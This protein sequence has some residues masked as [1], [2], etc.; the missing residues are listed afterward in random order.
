ML[1]AGVR[2]NLIY[3]NNRP[4]HIQ[5]KDVVKIVP[6]KLI[7]DGIEVETQAGTTIMETADQMGIEIPRLCYDPELSIYGGCR[8]CVVEVEGM[9]N[10][11]ASCCT[12]AQPGMVIH[13]KNDRVIEARR[14]ILSLMLADHPQNCMTCDKMGDC[15]LAR[16]CY[17]YGV[18]KSRFERSKPVYLIDDSNPFIIRDPNKCILCGKC[19]RACTEVSGIGNLSFAFRSNRTKVATAGDL[20][21]I[22]SDC[23]FC[24]AC[25]A[26]CPTGALVERSMHGKGRRWETEKIKTTCSFCGT[27][28]NFDLVVKDEKVIGVQSNPSSEVNGRS[29]CVKGRFGWDYIYNEKRLTTPLIKKNGQFEPASWE[30]ALALTATRL[31]ETKAQHGPDALAVL[32]SARCTNEDNYLLQK[33]TRAALGTNN[34]DHC[35][36]T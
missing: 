28:C 5:A 9:R 15:D 11:Q 17:E 7:I 32:S 34:I 31:L 2:P 30:E 25:V 1:H 36:R 18:E 22:D 23:T 14:E 3:Q 8:I 19:V 4:P 33:L 35:A 13:T 16:Y 6:V 29:L 21:Y 10:L 20:P 27:G 24:G 12:Q 26:V